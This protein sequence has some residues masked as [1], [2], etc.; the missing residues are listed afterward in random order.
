MNNRVPQSNSSN[1]IHTALLLISI[2]VVFCGVYL[3]ASKTTKQN[4][5]HSDDNKISIRKKFAKL[6]DRGIRIAKNEPP[7]GKA[8]LNK[9]K[10][11]ENELGIVQI[12]NTN[13]SRL[14][15]IETNLTKIRQHVKKYQHVIPEKSSSLS[16]LAQQL[17][18]VANQIKSLNSKRIE[19]SQ[20]DN[21]HSQFV[22]FKRE[23]DNDI[24]SEIDR[25]VRAP[26]AKFYADYQQN[27]DSIT[28]ENRSLSDQIQQIRN[29]TDVIKRSTRDTIA[30]QNRQ[31]EFLNDKNEIERLLQPFITPAFVQLGSDYTDWRKVSEKQPISYR[32]LEASGALDKGIKGVE[33]M[34]Y[35]GSPSYGTKQYGARPMG[36]FPQDIRSDSNMEKVK[37]AQELIRKHSV[38]LIEN[39]LL[40]P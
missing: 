23:R 33:T 3:I 21:L 9:V 20:F 14:N 2:P 38:Y 31:Q 19:L 34:L 25:R 5:E 13:R 1:F 28:G 27:L 35:I 30:K 36:S 12:S 40:H 6:T 10:E 39:G 17:H 15:Q 24:Q 32:Q 37:R 8:W 4:S 18:L 26:L 29:E 7:P 16:P 11:L 22:E